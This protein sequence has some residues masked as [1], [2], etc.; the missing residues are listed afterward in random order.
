M[1]VSF[2]P[3]CASVNRFGRHCQ[4]ARESDKHIDTQQP[5]AF[6]HLRI[7]ERRTEVDFTW[8]VVHL[9]ALVRA[10]ECCG[11]IARLHKYS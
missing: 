1:R 3:G 10:L 6:C 7:D 8:N 5:G 9:P 2:I 4:R 11:Y